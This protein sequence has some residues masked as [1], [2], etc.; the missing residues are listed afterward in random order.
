MC[1]RQSRRVIWDMINTLFLTLQLSKLLLLLSFSTR[2]H[3]SMTSRVFFLNFFNPFAPGDF[4]ASRVVFWSLSCYKELKP[5]KKSVYRWYTSWPSDPHA[6]YQFAKFRHA[7]KA[8]FRDLGF[9]SDTA[10][11]TFTF[12]FLSSP[13]FSLFLPHFFFLL[14]I[15]QASFC[16]NSFQESFQDLRIR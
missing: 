8:K 3:K 1:T 13:R 4:E 6:K 11:L 16:G 14:G 5:T 12:R 9:K 10:V 15:Q 2:K 7:Q